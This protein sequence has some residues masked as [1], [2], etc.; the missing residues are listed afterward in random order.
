MSRFS[1]LF[2]ALRNAAAR[3]AGGRAGDAPR[4]PAALRPIVVTGGG[5]APTGGGGTRSTVPAVQRIPRSPV[6]VLRVAEAGS[7]R[8]AGARMVISGRLADVCAELERLAAL[9]AAAT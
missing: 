6:R 7:R 1:S 5:R 3:I 2:R 9:E 4:P 8:V